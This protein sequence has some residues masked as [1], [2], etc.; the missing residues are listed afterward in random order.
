M[1]VRVMVVEEVVMM[2]SEVVTMAVVR[3]VVARLTAARAVAVK[4][5]MEREAPIGRATQAREKLRCDVWWVC[6][7]DH[8]FDQMDSGKITSTVGLTWLATLA[9]I[10]ATCSRPGA[11]GKDAW[12]LSGAIS[13]WSR[14]GENVLSVSDFTWAREGL[15]ITMP[16]GSIEKGSLRAELEMTRIKGFYDLAASGGY[17]YQM[18]LTADAM[19]QA[20]RILTVWA[21]YMFHRGLF[22]VQYD[23]MSKKAIEMAV[24]ARGAADGFEGGMPPGAKIDASEAL[25]RWNAGNKSYLSQLKDEPLLVMLNRQQKLTTKEK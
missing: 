11:I 6:L 20:R 9:L 7:Q 3:V 21:A 1:V 10:R 16:D 22:A 24:E 23:G 5:A 19:A 13:K 14:E 4:V 2:A 17:D 8:V 25:L 18:S 15:N 12:D